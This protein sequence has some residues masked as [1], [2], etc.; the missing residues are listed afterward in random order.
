MVQLPAARRAGFVSL[1]V[2]W[3]GLF[4]GLAMVAA[5]WSSETLSPGLAFGAGF[6]LLVGALAFFSRW[7]RGGGGRGGVSGLAGM[8]ARNSAWNPGRSMLSVA[9]VGAACFMVVVV[10]VFRIDP[11]S[12]EA[13]AQWLPDPMFSDG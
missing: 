11:A 12:E 8:A 13:L 10:E 5:A 7:C 9:L 2:A 1:L 3:G 6:A 4:S